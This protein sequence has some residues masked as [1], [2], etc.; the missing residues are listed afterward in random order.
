MES[1]GSFFCVFDKKNYG[2]ITT[3]KTSSCIV[4]FTT[5]DT[6]VLC[7][8]FFTNSDLERKSL[9]FRCRDNPPNSVF[10][11][12]FGGLL[13]ENNPPNWAFF[14]DFGGLSGALAYRFLMLKTR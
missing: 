11:I 4:F 7:C 5:S 1:H 13:G 2:K 12:E 8:I 10:F 6:I 14:I 9:L 3:Q